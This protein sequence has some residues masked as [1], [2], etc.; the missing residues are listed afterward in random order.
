[1][2]A[3]L[4]IYSLR[5][6]TREKYVIAS[7]LESAVAYMANHHRVMISV[8]LAHDNVEVADEENPV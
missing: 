5:G 3:F 1:M 7:T 2:K 6:D 8:S 4:V